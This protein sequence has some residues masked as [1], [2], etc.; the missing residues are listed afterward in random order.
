MVAGAGMLRLFVSGDEA[1]GPS[2]ATAQRAGLKVCILAMRPH[3]WAKNVLLFVPMVLAHDFRLVSLLHAGAAFAAF[4]FCASAIYLINDIRD[5][6]ADRRHPTKRL[7]PIAAG[8][9]SL[10]RG[11]LL[12]G[13]LLAGG[14]VVGTVTGSWLFLGTLLVYLALTSLYSFSLKRQMVVDVMLL[15]NLYVLR[16]MAGGIASGTPVSEW[17]LAFSMFLFLSLAFIKRYVELARLADAGHPA[18]NSRGYVVAD[19]SLIESL[20]STSGYLAGPGA[21][22][23]HQ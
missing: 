7:R 13:G 5:I 9:L 2:Q 11:I 23:V 18:C 4:C 6:D 14:L 19:L 12:A 10:P 20:G 21:C 16:I 22:V 8:E 17:L 15:A 1:S 3:H